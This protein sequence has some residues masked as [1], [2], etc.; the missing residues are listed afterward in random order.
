MCVVKGTS[1]N[2]GVGPEQ[3]VSSWP[4]LMIR[5]IVLFMIT[6]AISCVYAYF[7]DAPLKELAN[8]QVPE[9]PAKAP[10]YFLGLQELVSYS[11]FMGG[12]GIPIFTLLGLAL[13]PYLDREKQEI[14]VWPNDKNSKKV[15][16]ETIIF[17]T[18]AVILMLIVTVSFG[19]IRNW[20]PE[21]PQLVI[22]FLNPGTILVGYFVYLS[23]SY[24]IKYDSTRLAAISLFSSFLVAFII[25][26]YFA[27]FHRGPNWEFYWFQSQWPVH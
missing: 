20:F 26:T 3:T 7:A 1:N 15:I 6:F 8:P 10:W 14:G 22:T 13:I 18:V 19:W 5:V 11:A 9:N 16:V 12:I 24:L 25:L 23:L 2:V 21:T 4:H 17:S 27:I